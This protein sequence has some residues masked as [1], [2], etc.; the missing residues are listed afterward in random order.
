M[1][2]LKISDVKIMRLAAACW[3]SKTTLSI[4]TPAS[5]FVSLRQLKRAKAPTP[6]TLQ[7]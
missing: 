6:A 5:G 2:R 1:R 3:S 4:V 7:L